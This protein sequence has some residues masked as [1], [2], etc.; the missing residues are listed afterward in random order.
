MPENLVFQASSP[1]KTCV[2]SYEIDSALQSGSQLCQRVGVQQFDHQA[3][4]LCVA[5]AART[6]QAIDQNFVNLGW[7]GATY[8][9]GRLEPL[10]Q[11]V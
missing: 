9:P 6:A 3:D 11:S 1:G 5:L 7:L 10:P 2:S 8:G 4:H